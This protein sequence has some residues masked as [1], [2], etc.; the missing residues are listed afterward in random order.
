MPQETPA[1]TEI[2]TIMNKRERQ[3]LTRS[4]CD[5]QPALTVRSD[6]SKARSDACFSVLLGQESA[7]LGSSVMRAI[8]PDCADGESLRQVR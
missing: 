4:C 6:R 3:R 5:R 1:A 8:M 7:R 2:W